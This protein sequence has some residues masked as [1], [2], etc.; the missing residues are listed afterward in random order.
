MDRPRAVPRSILYS[1]P[2][3][4]PGAISICQLLIRRVPSRKCPTCPPMVSNVHHTLFLT[5]SLASHPIACPSHDTYLD[6]HLQRVCSKQE[7]SFPWALRHP[8]LTGFLVCGV[9]PRATGLQILSCDSYEHE[10]T[11]A[12]APR[13]GCRHT[14][15]MVL[16]IP[17]LRSS[18]PQTGDPG[19]RKANISS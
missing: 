4:P 9:M 19:G 10:R 12:L 8:E 18:A 7:A 17:D 14:G 1:I 6:A 2:F 5:A 16:M 3:F 13:N 11:R 15:S